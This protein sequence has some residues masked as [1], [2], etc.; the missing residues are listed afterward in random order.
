MQKRLKE[1]DILR[2]SQ[3]FTRA[4]LLSNASMRKKAAINSHH[5]PH[6]L[7]AMLLIYMPKSTAQYVVLCDLE[8]S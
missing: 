8:W 3:Q 7:R 2:S 5:L 1:Q 6:S 4:A